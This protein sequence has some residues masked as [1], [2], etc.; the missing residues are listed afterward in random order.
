MRGC[1]IRKIGLLA[2]VFAL[3][4]SGILLGLT[5]PAGAAA[6]DNIQ[7]WNTQ[8][9]I[10]LG[11]TGGEKDASALVWTCNNHADQQWRQ[12]KEYGSTGYHQLVNNDNQCLGVYGGSA[13]EGAHV[14]GWDCLTGHKDQYWKWDTSRNC[15]YQSLTYNTLDN[16]N[17][18]DVLGVEANS[19]TSGAGV[20]IWRFQ[21][22][23]NNQFWDYS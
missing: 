21:G 2:T 10:C 20:I 4:P 16:L 1:L 19:S 18:G 17:S 6:G 13:A 15:S 5:A 11:I 23:C 14:V 22:P 3:V 9:A 12:G 8:G 7:N